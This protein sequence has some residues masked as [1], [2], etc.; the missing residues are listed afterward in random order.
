MDGQGVAGLLDEAADGHGALHHGREVRV[1][2]ALVVGGRDSGVRRQ[3]AW[4]AGVMDDG[5]RVGVEGAAAEVGAAKGHVEPV[6]ARGARSVDGDVQPLADGEEDA[7]GGIGV[8]GDQ[9]IGDDGHGVVDE[10][11]LEVVLD[12]RVDE[13]EAVALARGERDVGVLAG[14]CRRVLG[15]AVEEHVVA[16]GRAVVL[17]EEHQLV[18]SL[19]VVVGDRERPQVDVVGER[20]RPVDLDG[21]DNAV[22]VLG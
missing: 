7:V 21:A 13:A 14:A 1:V 9:V 8:D 6:V 20:C 2:Q 15:R 11:D 19:V 3:A 18:G 5:G 22:A 12:R 10:R 17:G 4:R 16:E